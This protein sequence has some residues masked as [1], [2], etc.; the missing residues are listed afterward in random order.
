M[1]C[2]T[3]E[4]A[5]DLST[6]LGILFFLIQGKSEDK[7]ARKRAEAKYVFSSNEIVKLALDLVGIT[8]AL[9]FL[10]WMVP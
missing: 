10:I 2:I 9:R 4:Y 6:L 5:S 8:L 7:G 3:N 1:S